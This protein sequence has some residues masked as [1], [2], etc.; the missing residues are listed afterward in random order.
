MSKVS[1][2]PGDDREPHRRRHAPRSVL[3]GTSGRVLTLLCRGRKTVNELAAHLHLTD[4]AV[5]AQL[6]RLQRA[7]LVAQAGS[8]P[9]TRKPHADYEITPAARRLFPT[10]YE[11]VL[12]QL[13][14]LLAQRL[15]P[16][17]AVTLLADA[18]EQL[19]GTLLEPRGAATLRQQLA[20]LIQKLGDAGAA[21]DL[22]DDDEDGRLVV[23]ACACPLASVTA[24]RPLVCERLAAVLSRLL[25]ASVV[26]T[27]VHGDFPRC[28]FEVS[29]PGPARAR[30]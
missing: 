17:Q 10:A 4:N 14:R 20:R 2:A 24:D 27:C 25:K 30:K 1:A 9:G 13:I 23:T 12:N 15:S 6:E 22:D 7:G 3:T 29:S 16:E 11:P 26:Q 5:R 21:L 28:R 19:L 8:R 18:G